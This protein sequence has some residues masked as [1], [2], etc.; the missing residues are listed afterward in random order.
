MGSYRLVGRFQI[1][2]TLLLLFS[3]G[4]FALADDRPFGEV[5]IP[6]ETGKRP[7][8]VLNG[9]PQLSI[10]I[11]DADRKQRAIVE[12][13][14]LIVSDKRDLY[15]VLVPV[16]EGYFGTLVN[17]SLKVPLYYQFSPNTPITHT[18]IGR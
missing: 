5:R 18:T 13:Q 17:Q 12:K 1:A 15:G 3:F 8:Y 11:F 7:L 14:V 4:R 9:G 6:G 16:A 10:P 2:V